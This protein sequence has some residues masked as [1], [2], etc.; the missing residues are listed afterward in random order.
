MS[1]QLVVGSGFRSAGAAQCSKS[2]PVY[3][4]RL[5]DSSS[6]C[7]QKRTRLFAAHMHLRAEFLGVLSPHAAGQARRNGCAAHGQRSAGGAAAGAGAAGDEK[8][9]PKMSLGTWPL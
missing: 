3:N 6:A 7:C 5:H 1:A 9:C 4:R 2:T 8:W